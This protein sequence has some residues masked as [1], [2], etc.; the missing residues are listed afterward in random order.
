[1]T[2]QREASPDQA[3]SA[4]KRGPFPRTME[5]FDAQWVRNTDGSA[6]R[7]VMRPL[8]SRHRRLDDALADLPLDEPMLLTEL[9]GFLTGLLVAPELVAPGEWLPIVWGSEQH[10]AAPFDDPLDVQWFTDAVMARHAEIA[11][12]L[13]RGKPRP[14]F[15]VD[16]RTGDVLWEL[17][18]DGFAEAMALRP[19]SWAAIARSGDASAAAALSRLS[20]LIAIARNESALDTIEINAIDDNA[21]DEI[22]TSIVALHACRPNGASAP[23]EASAVKVGRNALCPCG[24]QKKFKRCCG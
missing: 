9:D 23:A 3:R 16:D 17:W 5:S 24:S 15:D 12:D 8:P 10:G 1:M 20:L 2:R 6:I 22:A 7:R 11:R 19:E 14:I 13:G 4:D 21:A 18:I